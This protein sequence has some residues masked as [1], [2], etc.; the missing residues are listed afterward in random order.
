MLE[1]TKTEQCNNVQHA[2]RDLKTFSEEM[3]EWFTLK[4]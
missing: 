4:E 3:K 1:S 2:C